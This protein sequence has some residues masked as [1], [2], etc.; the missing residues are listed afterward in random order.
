MCQDSVMIVL[1]KGQEKCLNSVMI[2]LEK[3]LNSVMIVL[4]K[5]QIVS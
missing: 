1:E 4:E 3:C 5:C 2:V